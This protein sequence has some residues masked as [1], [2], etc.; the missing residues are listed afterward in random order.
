M[1]KSCN[2]LRPWVGLSVFSL[3]CSLQAASD[4]PPA[5]V[6]PFAGLTAQEAAAKATLPP[7]FQMHVF[8]AEPD[9][10]QPIAFCL[11]DRGRVWVAEGITYPKRRG[12]PPQEAAGTDGGRPTPAQL[13]DIFGGADR[14]LVLEDTDGDHRFDKKTVFLENVNLIS[15]LAVGFGGVWIGAAP[16]LLFVPIQEGDQPKPAGDPKILLDGWNYSADTHETLNT[17]TWGPDG[18]LYGCHGVFCPSNVGKPGVAETERQWMDAGVW[19]YH[20]VRHVF[21]VFTEGGSNPWGIDFDEYGQ[22]FAEMCVIPHFWH[23]IQGARIERRSEERR[24]GKEC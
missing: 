23:M 13:K 9:V 12:R 20:P 4:A 18:W 3:A 17:L 21:D 1:T 2:V 14:I 16:Y 8:A 10:R 19:R 24:V 7:G 15:G 6:V 11:D 5:D 22:L